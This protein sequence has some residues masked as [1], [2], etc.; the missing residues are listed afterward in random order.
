MNFKNTKLSGKNKI[1]RDKHSSGPHLQ[2]SEILKT[3]SYVIPFK[4]G[5]PGGTSGKELACQCRRW[6]RCRFNSWVGKIPWS[7]AWQPILVFLPKEPHVQ[8]RL[9]DYSAWSCKSWTRL[10]RLHVH[11]HLGHTSRSLQ[12]LPL[13]K[14]GCRK[15][16]GDSSK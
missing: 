1:E 2:I 9:V 12:L 13:R 4:L 14:K 3:I 15:S 8:G 10:N 11:M 6:E 16:A 5:F 7:R